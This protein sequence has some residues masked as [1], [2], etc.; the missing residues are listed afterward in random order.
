MLSQSKSVRMAAALALFFAMLAPPLAAQRSAR[1][2]HRNIAQLVQGADVIFRGEVI[3]A[4]VEKHPTLTALNTVVVTLRV[5]E[6]LKGQ[7]GTEYTFRQYLW[8]HRDVRS[9]LDYAPGQQYVLL[10]RNP[11]QEGLSSPSGHE[12]G[13]FRISIDSAGNEVATNGYDNIR[14]M[15]GIDQTSPNLKISL[16]PALRARVSQHQRGPI[17]YQDLKEVIRGATVAGN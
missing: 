11:S 3:S 7:L 13:R 2:L 9:K 5:Q 14:L 1:V 12:Q 4:K 10:M 8:D 15:D 6:V 17:S 16:T